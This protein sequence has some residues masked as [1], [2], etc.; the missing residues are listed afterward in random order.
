MALT[1]TREEYRKIYGVEPPRPKS[2][3]LDITP[4]PR[5][6]TRAEY[7]AEFLSPEPE[8]SKV[9]KVLEGEPAFPANKDGGVLENLARYTGNIPGATYNLAKFALSPINPL[10]TKSPFNIGKNIVES[11][12]ALKDIYKNRGTSGNK[13]IAIGTS[14]TAKKGIDLVKKA[15]ESI[16]KNLEQNVFNEDSVAKGVGV[17]A[18]Q[19]LSKVAELAINDP[20]LFPTLIYTPGKVIKGTDAIS[21]TANLVTQPAET[22]LKALRNLR[23]E[24]ITN[25]IADEIANIENNYV[26][27]RKANEFSKDA[28]ASR[29]RI[30]Q[31]DALVG[32]VDAEG[33]I[34]TKLPGGAVDKYRA[35][36]LDGSEDVVKKLLV[37]EGAKVNLAEV[38]RD[39]TQ[40]VYASG[41][42]GA[43]LIRAVNG[44]KAELAGLRLRADDF[45]N[46]LLDKIHDAK[47]STT[48]Q[49]NYKTDSTP[50]ITYRKAKARAYKELIENKSKVKVN[51]NG[52]EHDI[53]AVNKELGK[54][55]EDIA[56]LELL[57][58]RKVKGGKLG[59]YF[60]QISG[61]LI[62]GAAGAA[63]GGGAMGMAL[64]AVVGGEAAGF[65]KGR[66]MART[67]QNARG[68]KVSPNPILEEAKLLGQQAPKLDLTIPS[69]KVGVPKGIPKTKEI[70]KLEGDITRNIE[71]QKK[72][73]RMGDFALV[74]ALKE[75]Y[76]VLVE[77]LADLVKRVKETPNKQGG[78]IDYSKSL[79]NRK[80]QYQSKNATTKK[81]ILSND[82]SISPD[83]QPLTQEARKYKSA[84][85]YVADR[86]GGKVT[87]YDKVFVQQVGMSK[88][89]AGIPERFKTVVGRGIDIKLPD[90]RLALRMVE[91][92][93]KINI[94]GIVV[95]KTGGGTGTKALEAIRDYATA[96]GKEVNIYKVTNPEY[97][98]KIGWLKKGGDGSYSYVPRA[99]ETPYL[100]HGTTEARA[101]QMINSGMTSGKRAG[102][103]QADD[104][105]LSNTEQYAKSYADRKGGSGGVILRTTKSSDMVGDINTGLAGDFKTAKN[106]SADDLQIKGKDGSWYNLKEYDFESGK[107]LNPMGGREQLVPLMERASKYKSVDEFI[108]SFKKGSDNA[109]CIDI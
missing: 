76:D 12:I 77:K 46:I 59:K 86:L 5:M 38:G 53:P 25:K 94:S 82:T 98:D 52:I 101:R 8:K 28:Q 23:N 55:Y 43:D 79:G 72:A 65:M 57:D 39:L 87:D 35:I 102:N 45:G 37:R 104:I 78:F 74:K 80:T 33:T 42:E 21:K 97:F 36:T 73:I 60:A 62:G 81:V 107:G 75:I 58:G 66:M 99:T 20:T 19:A 29:Q 16:Y 18:G 15:G 34:R 54:Y 105:F 69:P 17:S 68:G 32:A 51:V 108:N 11:A 48:R 24:S 90:N 61:N 41:L 3:G 93:S 44:L 96:R 10:D 56:R 27:T 14:D 47:I 31:T 7:E 92:S 2:S 109:Y 85:D 4:A 30:A 71:A 88:V 40:A 9:K 103:T 63:V 67:F 22:T 95:E 64:G 50:T 70:L 1:M 49:I 26:V 106:I 6:M 91:D 89:E 83:L 13:D 100:Y 84:E